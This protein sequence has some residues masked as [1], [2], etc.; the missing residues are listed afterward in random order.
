MVFERRRQIDYATAQA[1]ECVFDNDTRKGSVFFS[2][3]LSSVR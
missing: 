2:P 1:R 3:P